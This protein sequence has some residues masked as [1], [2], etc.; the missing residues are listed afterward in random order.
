MN[1]RRSVALA[2]P[3]LI[4]AC[5]S[6]ASPTTSASASSVGAAV[7]SLDAGKL[8]SLPTGGVFVRVI[9]FV[10][11]S[12]YTVKSKQHVPGFVYVESGVHRLTLEGQSPI[13]VTAGQAKFHL[14][15]THTHFNP[16]PSTSTW[17]FIAL[18]PSSS[19]GQPLV[20]AIARQMFPTDDFSPEQLPQGAYSEVLRQVTLAASGRSAA[21]RFG[22]LAAFFVLQGS[23]VVR[24]SQ[25]SVALSADEGAVYAP[26]VPLQ[27]INSAAGQTVYLE[28]MTTALGREFEVPLSQSPKG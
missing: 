16:G 7:R 5:G 12:G 17:Y 26:G 27:E 2:T 24:S 20:D 10:Q 6:P 21:H 25:G 3:L 4:L 18:W 8:D 9:K 14:S 28:M 22:G 11:P 19:R 15:I 23:L 13:D 1:V